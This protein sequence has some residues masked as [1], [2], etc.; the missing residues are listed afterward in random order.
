M[1]NLFYI[2]VDGPLVDRRGFAIPSG[3]RHGNRPTPRQPTRATATAP[4]HG[5]QPARPR[6]SSTS[7]AHLAQSR[8]SAPTGGAAQLVV[9]QHVRGC[10]AGLCF[11]A[12]RSCKAPPCPSLA[13]GRCTFM[14]FITGLARLLRR[15]PCPFDAAVPVRVAPCA[16]KSMPAYASGPRAQATRT[17]HARKC[18]RAKAS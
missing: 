12:V 1:V 15:R 14:T 11:L 13:A 4:R 9:P 17:G 10:A 8:W 5:N 16:S 2:K 6:T 18:K 7:T 3:A